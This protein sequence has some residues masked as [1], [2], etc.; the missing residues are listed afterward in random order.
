MTP[1]KIVFTKDEVIKAA[2]LII[3]EKGLQSVTARNVAKML[4]S[5]VAPV[6]SHFESM[7][8]LRGKA[9]RKG[10]ERLF[11]YTRKKHTDRVFLNM[12]I[13]IA[14]FARD[15]RQLFKA[16]F[17]EGDE[18]RDIINRFL[19]TLANEMKND[20]RFTKM[21][22]Q[23]RNELLHKMW[24]FSFGLAT[25]INTGV[26]KN[27]SKEFIVKMLLDVGSDVIGATFQK[28]KN[29]LHL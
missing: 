10:V 11:E 26:I 12:G 29:E 20:S 2:F 25:L 24:I 21:P 27:S 14:L 18:F 8:K 16:I 9:I 19:A 7:E 4:K 28:I 17:L 13:G 23:H 15:E 6:Y 22:D 5:S 3:P 1:R